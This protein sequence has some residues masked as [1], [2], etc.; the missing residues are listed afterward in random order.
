M[1]RSI[2]FAGF[3]GQGILFA[4]KVLARAAM[5]EDREVLWIPSYGP[6]MRG[7]TA[8][9]TVIIGDE[10]IG[11]PVVDLADAAVV[12]NPPSHAKFAPLVKPGGLLVVNETLVG[13]I[14]GRT[15][16]SELRLPCTRLAKDAGDDSLVS[17]VALGALV[18]YLQLVRPTS[19]RNALRESVGAKRLD[20]LAADLTAFDVG[21]RVGTRSRGSRSERVA[22]P[23]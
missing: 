20:V 14:S 17:V 11:S 7:G 10:P 4:G 19:A 2:I 22:T 8:S 15:D 12:L 6:E 18:G 13:D 9:C 3:G 21:Y 16:L 1:E 5:N 23:A